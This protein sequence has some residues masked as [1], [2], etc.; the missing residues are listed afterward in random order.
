MSVDTSYE[1]TLIA[2]A[3][4]IAEETPNELSQRV[5]RDI[6]NKYSHELRRKVIAVECEKGVWVL[7][8]ALNERREM[9]FVERVVHYWFGWKPNF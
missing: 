5:I 7:Y 6:T 4:K 3:E 2:L 1:R 9:T 8:N